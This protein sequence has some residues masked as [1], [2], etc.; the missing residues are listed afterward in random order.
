MKLRFVS[1][2]ALALA[3]SQITTAAALAEQTAPY[4]TAQAQ[5]FSQQD[6]QRYGLSQAD[7]AQVAQ[8]QSEGYQVQTLSEEEAQQYRAGLTTGTWIIIGLVVVV[9]IAVAAAD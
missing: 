5:T 1:A 7:A 4:R 9:V 2:V 8:L 3:F 6:L